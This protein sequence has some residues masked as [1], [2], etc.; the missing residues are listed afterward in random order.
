MKTIYD[1]LAGGVFIP[2][3]VYALRPQSRIEAW[4]LFRRIVVAKRKTEKNGFVFAPPKSWRL[5]MQQRLWLAF[6]PVTAEAQVV[7]EA[8]RIQ[9]Q[10]EITALFKERGLDAYDFGFSPRGVRRE[11]RSD[12]NLVRVTFKV[13][14]LRQ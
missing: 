12:V 2:Y 10:N 14:S 13:K 7:L 1:D 4:S 8:S 9:A 3:S 6:T 5:D 11:K